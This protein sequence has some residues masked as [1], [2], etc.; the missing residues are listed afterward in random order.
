MTRAVLI[1]T[2]DGPGGIAVGE[3]DTPRM[4]AAGEVTRNGPDRRA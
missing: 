4:D 1:H 3:R 2:A